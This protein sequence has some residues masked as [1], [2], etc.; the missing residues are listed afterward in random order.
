MILTTNLGQSFCY[1]FQ[2]TNVEQAQRGEGS[3]YDHTA[4]NGT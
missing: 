2:L 4:D 3:C 1:S